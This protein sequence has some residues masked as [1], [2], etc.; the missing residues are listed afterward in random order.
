MR[1]V[2]LVTLAAALLA[3]PLLAAPAKPSLKALLITGGCCHDYDLQSKALIDGAKRHA[4]I[5]WT[6]VNEGGKGTEAEIP[7][8]NNPEWAKP[9]DVVV[10][11]ECFANTK[12]PDY[13][14]K[15]TAAHKAGKPAV[16]I[17]CA[18]HSFPGPV[19]HAEGR[20]LHHRKT[21]A[22]RDRARDVQE[23]EGWQRAARDLD[24]PLPRHPRLRHDLRPQQRHL[25]R[26]RVRHARHPRPL[27]GRR[28][29]T[30]RSRGARMSRA[31]FPR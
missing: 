1:L 9:Y 27:L 23:R 14:R 26:P 25:A 10:H 13:I 31:S 18:M 2:T 15:I 29:L 17:H 6:I 22:D 19:D 7:L 11:N 21:L 3:G 8:Y 20:T 28:P 30:L 24:Q 4:D 16:V 12:N 5:A